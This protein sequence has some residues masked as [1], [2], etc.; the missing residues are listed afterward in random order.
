MVSR[1]HSF[2][3]PRTP[4]NLK[5][6]QHLLGRQVRTVSPVFER[7]RMAFQMSPSPFGGGMGSPG[8]VQAQ[9]GPDL[10]EIQTEVGRWSTLC[11]GAR[12][13]E[14]CRPSGSQL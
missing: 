6:S 11:T 2:T 7:A 1:R 3:V 8:N 13:N 5:S 10:D 4:P 12:S 9:A 14:I